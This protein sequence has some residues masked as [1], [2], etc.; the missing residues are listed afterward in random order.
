MEMEITEGTLKDAL[1]VLNNLP[2]F[3]PLFSPGYYEEKIKD[4]SPL[5][6]VAKVDGKLAGCKVGYDKFKD[7]SFY[8][9]LGGVIPEYRRLGL[10]KEL[11]LRQEAWALQKGFESVKFKTLNRHKKMLTF[12][13]NH[14]FDIYNLKPKDELENYR[15]ELIKHLI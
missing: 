2:E 14:G 7:G 13:L 12:A 9:W 15:I 6:L 4:K 3:D 10:A 5:I 1:F 11:A 8:S